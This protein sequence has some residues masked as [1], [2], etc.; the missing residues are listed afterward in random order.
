MIEY[1]SMLL[2][3]KGMWVYLGE[4]R[5]EIKLLMVAAFSEDDRS[6]SL[7][8]LT[9]ESSIFHLIDQVSTYIRLL[10]FVL[11]LF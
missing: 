4:K 7:L 8:T 5:R 2:P 1:L 11:F 10:F 3:G 6:S 9:I